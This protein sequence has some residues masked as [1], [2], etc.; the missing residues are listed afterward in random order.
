MKNGGGRK[1]LKGVHLAS[2]KGGLDHG[3]LR[4]SS[5]AERRE[6]QN[7]HISICPDKRNHRQIQGPLTG[8]RECMG[9]RTSEQFG[10]IAERGRKGI[11]FIG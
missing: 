2:K 7:H 5:S 11:L 1:G 4:L 8:E 3:I 6:K 10:Q 9:R